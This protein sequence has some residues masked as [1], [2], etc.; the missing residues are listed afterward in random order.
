[1]A[2]IENLTKENRSKLKQE[3]IPLVSHIFNYLSNKGLTPSLKGKVAE[4]N[5]DYFM[6]HI[7][8]KG[9]PKSVFSVFNDFYDNKGESGIFTKGL[10]ET[11]LIENNS[12][13]NQGKSSREFGLRYD[14]SFVQ[15]FLESF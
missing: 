3:H 11:Y 5:K 15:L 10:K 12:F 2:N 7:I 6:I 14:S 8:G 13:E 1:M 4:G 9:D